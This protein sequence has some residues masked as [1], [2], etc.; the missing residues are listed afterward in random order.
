MWIESFWTFLQNIFQLFETM[1][2]QFLRKKVHYLPQEHASQT[3]S[4]NIIGKN[5]S[6]LITFLANQD[7]T[8]MLPGTMY[9]A[10]LTFVMSRRG[11]VMNSFRGGARRHLGGE[12]KFYLL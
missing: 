4:R 9:T 8:P 12:L 3:N 5:P 11:P 7:L 6:M 2:C 10:L 1:C